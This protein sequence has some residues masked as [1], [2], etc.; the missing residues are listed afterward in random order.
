MEETAGSVYISPT[1]DILG[2]DFYDFQMQWFIRSCNKMT[3]R[4]SASLGSCGSQK[5]MK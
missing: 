3:D 1:V 4:Q 5:N 2:S